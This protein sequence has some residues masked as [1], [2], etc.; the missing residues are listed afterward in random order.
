[1]AL[2][3]QY[4]RCYVIPLLSGAFKLWNGGHVTAEDGIERDVQHFLGHVV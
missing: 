4:N 3:H 2:H 1:M